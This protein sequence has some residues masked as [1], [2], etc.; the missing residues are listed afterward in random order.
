MDVR[1]QAD[2]SF[3]PEAVKRAMAATELERRRQENAPEAIR[4]PLA[5]R[6]IFISGLLV[7]ALAAAYWGL[8]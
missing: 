8:Y 1:E 2:P 5:P 7:V 3:Q 4:D 6:I